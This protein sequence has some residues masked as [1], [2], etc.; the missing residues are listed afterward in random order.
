MFATQPTPP[1]E[2]IEPEVG[3]DQTKFASEEPLFENPELPSVPVP[4]TGKQK[5]LLLI[6]GVIAISVV[7]LALAGMLALSQRRVVPPQVVQASPSPTVVSPQLQSQL[8]K[9]SDELT[10]ADPARPAI[11]FPQVDMDIR[12]DPATK[13]Q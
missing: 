9:L 4:V 11:V 1:E 13:T 5:N 2:K 12:L 10:A 3:L 8:E 6:G 7:S